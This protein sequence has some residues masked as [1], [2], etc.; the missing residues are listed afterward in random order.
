MC[1]AALAA[2]GDG[3][4]WARLVHE[5]GEIETQTPTEFAA[6]ITREGAE[7]SADGFRVAVVTRGEFDK[8]DR[9]GGRGSTFAQ[10]VEAGL[11][12][13]V[14]GVLHSCVGHGLSCRLAV[15]G[16]VC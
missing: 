3:P 12:A 4:A 1:W 15:G 7:T 10:G 9:F 13:L 14:E 8:R 16:A 2:M 11:K 5:G 6:T